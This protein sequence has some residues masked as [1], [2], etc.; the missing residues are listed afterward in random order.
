LLS[1]PLHPPGKP[2]ALRTAHFPKLRTQAALVHGSKDPFGS[3]E[4]MEAALTK[5]AAPHKLIV[6]EGAG[7]DLRRGRFDLDILLSALPLVRQKDRG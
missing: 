6:I 3:I 5:I 7:H 1:Y 4:E 2:E